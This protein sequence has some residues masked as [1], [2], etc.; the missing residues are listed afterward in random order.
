MD[1]IVVPSGAATLISPSG[2]ITDPTPIYKWNAVQG[3]TWY[4]LWVNDPTGAKIQRWYRASEVGCASGTGTC[5]VEPK[6]VLAA[7]A[8]KWWIQTWFTNTAGPWSATMSFTLTPPPAAT[9]VS[10]SGAISTATPTYTWNAVLDSSWYFLWVDDASGTKIQQ[11]YRASEAG[12]GSGTGTCSGTPNIPLAKGAGKWW[13]QTWSAAGS[14]P[15]SAGMNFTVSP[16]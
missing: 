1:F 16:P 15:W 6:E 11:W 7:G 8:G 4:Y 12:C 9:L 13:I 14:G 10:P 2:V 5:E 3:S